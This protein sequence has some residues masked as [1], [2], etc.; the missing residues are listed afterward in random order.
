MTELSRACSK[1]CQLI[2]ITV[3]DKDELIFIFKKA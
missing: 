1:M 2:P 3:K